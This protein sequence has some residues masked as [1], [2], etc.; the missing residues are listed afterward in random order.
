M[1]AMTPA[2]RQ[3]GKG[4]E[5]SAEKEYGFALGGPIIRTRPTSS[6]PMRPSA[7]TCR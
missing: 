5:D 2:E 6:S 7:S 4:K 1:R 3:P